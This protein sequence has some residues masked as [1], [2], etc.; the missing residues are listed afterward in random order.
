MGFLISSEVTD[1]LMY[2]LRYL[3]L[4][5]GASIHIRVAVVFLTLTTEK[6][7]SVRPNIE[8][9]HLVEKSPKG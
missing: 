3:S 2:A 7:F 5:R 6:T 9:T 4:L 1:S 8:I